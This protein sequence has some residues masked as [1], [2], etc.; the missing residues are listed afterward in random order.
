ML[1]IL[2][3][4]RVPLIPLK[5]KLAFHSNL[6]SFHINPNKFSQ[7]QKGNKTKYFA[8]TFWNFGVEPLKST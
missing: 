7:N 4:H 1:K 5:S 8:K 6:L 3:I 2:R